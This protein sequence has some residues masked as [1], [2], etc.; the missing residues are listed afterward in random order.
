METTDNELVERVRG[1]EDDAFRILV[2]RHSRP[3]YRAAYRITS[4][5][6]DADDVVQEAFLRAYRAMASFDAR[7]TFATWLHRI[8]INCALDLIDSRK[9][10]D[11]R[12]ADGED[13]AMIA[14]PAAT[15]DRVVLSSEMQRAIATAMAGLTGN[16]R[17]A[18]VLRHF[19]GMPL[20][21]IGEVLGTRLNATKNTVFRAVKKL[22]QHLQPFTGSLV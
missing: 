18:F 20:E 11:G 17:T 22:R 19:E 1:G 21:E 9:R 3:L 12:I 14:S 8:A 4:N 2:E 7:A 6:A 5:A 10:R 16:E 15:P 13:L